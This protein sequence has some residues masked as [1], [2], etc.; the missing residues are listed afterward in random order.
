V[1]IRKK[2]IGKIAELNTESQKQLRKYTPAGLSQND[3]S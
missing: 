2:I 1:S 3:E